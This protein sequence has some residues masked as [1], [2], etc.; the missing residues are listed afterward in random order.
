M[1]NM[2]P[3]KIKKYPDKVL[4]RNCID[5]KEITKEEAELFEKMLFTMKHYC[6][7]GLAA[8]QIGISRKLIVAEVEGKTVKLANPQL[9]KTIGEDIMKEGCLSIPE[10]AIDIKR[11]Y[12]ITVKG[13]N[14]KGKDIEIKAEGLLARIIQHEIDHLKGRLIIDYVG[15]LEKLLLFKAKVKRDE[16]K[17]ANL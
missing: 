16:G 4:R 5:V 14:E 15:L 8:P 11:P 2:E 12:E 7:V 6:G 17:Y 3:L 1:S 10:I 13:L 9:I